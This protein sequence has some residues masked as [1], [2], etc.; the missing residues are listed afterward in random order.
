MRL[1]ASLAVDEGP[2]PSADYGHYCAEAALTRA[3]NAMQPVDQLSE[4]T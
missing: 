4:S 3:T 2:A 1:L